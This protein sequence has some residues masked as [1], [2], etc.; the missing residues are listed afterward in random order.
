M[1]LFGGFI[2]WTS[3]LTLSGQ[4]SVSPPDY[5]LHSGQFFVLGLFSARMAVANP[6]RNQ[7][8]RFLLLFSAFVFVTVFGGLD[9]I[10][11]RYVPLREA[12]I[13]DFFVDAAGGLVG[14]FVYHRLS[15]S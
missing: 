11:Q 5:F 3:S 1:I 14:V 9:E 4:Q 6:N 2:Y 10:H 15:R 7:K 12:S 13:K 8:H